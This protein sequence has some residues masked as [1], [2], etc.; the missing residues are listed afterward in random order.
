MR[1]FTPPAVGPVHVGNFT[2]WSY[3]H[4]G[5]LALAAAGLLALTG[6]CVRRPQVAGGTAR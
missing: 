3:P 2:V 6:A 5:G 1:N 4:A